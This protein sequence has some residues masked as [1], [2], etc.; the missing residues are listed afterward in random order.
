MT[1][2]PQGSDIQ[3]T[4]KRILRRTL[5][6]I[7]KFFKNIDWK[8]I[9]EQ[10]TKVC[11]RPVSVWTSLSEKE[12]F[13]RELLLNYLLPIAAL[14]PVAN[15]L[16]M[17]FF[18]EAISPVG[19]FYWGLFHG[20]ASTLVI[21]SLSIISVLIFAL[22]IRLLAS[23]FG[24]AISLNGGLKLSVYSLTPAFLSGILHLLPGLGS[25]PPLIGLY[26]VVLY[27]NAF[28]HF[29]GIQSEKKVPYFILTVGLS[30][31][32]MFAFTLLLGSFVDLESAL[33]RA[34]N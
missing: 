3:E 29:T 11:L 34:Q 9:F 17:I 24:G 1:G 10:S 25:I 26:G 13:N 23:Q 28:P 7:L 12:S 18:G 2:T 19:R 8:G 6:L 21:Y 22:S 33:G 4:A 32:L 5:N 16:K 31:A 14:G 27:W 30:F 20:I 15:L